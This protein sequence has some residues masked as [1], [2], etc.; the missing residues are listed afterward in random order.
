MGGGTRKTRNGME[1]KVHPFDFRKVGVKLKWEYSD[2]TMKLA[3][4]DRIF[5]HDQ[6]VLWQMYLEK[7]QDCGLLLKG[8][9]HVINHKSTTL[10]AHKQ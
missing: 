4:I 2:Q 8:S 6:S 7:L 5:G 3:G 9:A 10:E 1:I